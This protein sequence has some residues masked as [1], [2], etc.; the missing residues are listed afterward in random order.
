MA[1]WMAFEPDIRVIKLLKALDNSLRLKIVE[2]IINTSPVSF[3]AIHEHLEN[4]IGR[5]INKGTMSYHLDI[6]VQSDVLNREL[7]RNP[8]ERTYSRY[9]ITDYAVEKLEA[10]GLL[11]HIDEQTK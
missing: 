7:G 6:L 10:L 2:L 9:N 8:E 5:E 11:I 3:S 4:Q 1:W